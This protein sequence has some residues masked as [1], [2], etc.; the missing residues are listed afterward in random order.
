MVTLIEMSNHTQ[1]SQMKCWANNGYFN[2]INQPP[3]EDVD[4]TWVCGPTNKIQDQHV[5][6]YT[7]HVHSLISENLHGKTFARLTNKSLAGEIE[8]GNLDFKDK[9]S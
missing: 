1:T 3:E 2:P 4:S 9:D 6:G 8:P 7:G 5:P